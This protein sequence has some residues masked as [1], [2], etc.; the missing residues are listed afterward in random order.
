MPPSWGT[1]PSR[2]SA[3]INVGATTSGSRT[4]PPHSI[5]TR[6]PVS[7]LRCTVKLAQGKVGGWLSLGSSATP[8]VSYS[9]IL[10]RKTADSSASPRKK[11]RPRS[12][13]SSTSKARFAWNARVSSAPFP[14]VPLSTHRSSAAHRVRLVLQWLSSRRREELGGRRTK[15]RRPGE[16][17]GTS[18]RARRRHSRRLCSPPGRAQ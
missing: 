16:G 11:L 7:E 9:P 13:H 18:P 17:M 15:R 2:N 1:F 10:L 4:P 5:S 8:T 14:P 12:S 6:S 3:R